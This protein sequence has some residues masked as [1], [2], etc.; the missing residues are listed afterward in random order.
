[1]K[2]RWTQITD[3][4]EREALMLHGKW[5]EKKPTTVRRADA[6]WAL[7]DE[8]FKAWREGRTGKISC[9]NEK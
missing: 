5:D 9:R 1:M 7:V 2:D 6:L 8:P 4:A 3:A